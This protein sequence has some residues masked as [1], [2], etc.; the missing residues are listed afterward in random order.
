MSLGSRLLQSYLLNVLTEIFALGH[1]RTYTS[2]EL[3]PIFGPSR[4]FPRRFIVP[5]A[6]QK[7]WQD[8][9]GMNQWTMRAGL[10]S[11]TFE[12][13]DDWDHRMSLQRPFI[14]ETV[15]LGDRAA[16]HRGPSL[17]NPQQEFPITVKDLYW[18]PIRQSVVAFALPPSRR[19]KS[20]ADGSTPV[21]TYI[22]RQKTG[23][24]LRDEDH[25]ELVTALYRLG[26][27]HGYE[28]CFLHSFGSFV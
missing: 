14:L 13:K 7:E 25:D 1:W 15:V 26:R 21:I 2:P 9:A 23:R 17:K 19:P 20:N 6:T 22:S 5:R 18:E 8:R 16:W 27:D 11:L 3:D 10:P 24:R 12:Y 4:A 28:V